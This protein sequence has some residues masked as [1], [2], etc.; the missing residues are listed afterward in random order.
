M[1]NLTKKEIEEI[2]KKDKDK[3]KSIKDKDVILK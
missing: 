3:M 2:R 1:K